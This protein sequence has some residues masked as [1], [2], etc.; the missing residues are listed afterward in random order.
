MTLSLRS[1]A[2]RVKKRRLKNHA[3]R[4]SKDGVISKIWS[5]A[6]EETTA[7]EP[8]LSMVRSLELMVFA[9]SPFNLI[10]SPLNQP[11]LIV[12]PSRLRFAYRCCSVLLFPAGCCS[13]LFN[14]WK[15]EMEM[16]AKR[17]KTVRQKLYD[18][19]SSKDK[20]RN[21]WSFI[22]KQIGMFSFT[23]HSFNVSY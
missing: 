1:R 4:W 11:L 8:R 12:I 23:E 5:N 9:R 17:I 16:M 2:M 10:L 22:L 3:F 14:E 7:E 15:A 21:D 13:A 18:S 19:I 6:Y 20:N